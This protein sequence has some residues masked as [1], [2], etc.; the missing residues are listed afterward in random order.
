MS[1]S[2]EKKK[3]KDKFNYIR[4]KNLCLL[5]TPLNLCQFEH[6]VA[7]QSIHLHS[8]CIPPA[9]RPPF[10]MQMVRLCDRKIKKGE[11]FQQALIQ[12]HFNALKQGRF[13]GAPAKLQHQIM[14]LNFIQKFFLK[15]YT[16]KL[17]ITLLT[18]I[19]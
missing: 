16:F 13:E 8:S 9:I 4:D 1:S 11:K 2:A 5:I 6:I 14:T 18:F 7:F 10:Y 12:S 19:F 17:S 3:K 15:S